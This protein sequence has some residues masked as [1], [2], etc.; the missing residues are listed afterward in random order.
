MAAL[1]HVRFSW[2]WPKSVEGNSTTLPL[3]YN[4]RTIVHFT[5]LTY[6]QKWCLHG[7][8]TCLLPITSF[9]RTSVWSSLRKMMIRTTTNKADSQQMSAKYEEY[10]RTILISI[11]REGEL[12]KSAGLE[13]QINRGYQTFW[14]DRVLASL[15]TLNWEISRKILTMTPLI[16]V[17][18]YFI[19]HSP[20]FSL[21]LYLTYPPDA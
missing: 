20:L 19:S 12:P 10:R 14:T 9:H 13:W 3:Q 5:A 8:N 1:C 15:M 4:F 2:F 18:Q 17:Y 21:F 7:R 11:E 16:K 6:A